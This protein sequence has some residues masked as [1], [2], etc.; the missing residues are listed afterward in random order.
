MQ[1]AFEVRTFLQDICTGVLHSLLIW[2]FIPTDIYEEL[3][4]TTTLGVQGAHE[5]LAHYIS[6]VREAS[7]LLMVD[8]TESQLVD[9]ILVRLSLEKHSHLALVNRPKSFAELEQCCIHS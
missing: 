2:H 1:T 4:W 3:K 5:R 8:L 7:F 6:D 9:T